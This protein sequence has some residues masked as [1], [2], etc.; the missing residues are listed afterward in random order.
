MIEQITARM[1]TTDEV[2]KLG[3][4]KSTSVLDVYAA[5]RDPGGHPLAVLAVVL[6]GDR[7]ELEDAYPID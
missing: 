1:P 4:P 3:M 5:V 2:K 6:P 7:L